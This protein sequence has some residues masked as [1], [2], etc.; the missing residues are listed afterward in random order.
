MK[1]AFIRFL[2]LCPLILATLAMSAQVVTGTPAFGTFKSF[3]PTVLNIANLNSRVTIPIMGKP[4]RGTPFNYAMTYDNSVW[5]PSGDPGSLSWQP[6]PNFGWHGMSEAITGYLSYRTATRPCPDHVPGSR[7][8]FSNFVYHDKFG[9]PHSFL[10]IA[11]TDTDCDDARDLLSQ[12]A[13]DGSGYSLTF[14]PNSG[15]PTEIHFVNGVVIH[16]PENDPNGSG[17][18]AD[19]NGNVISTNMANGVGTFIDTLG[20]TALTVSGAA[21]N[22][23][24]LAYTDSNGASQSV[25]LNYQA[26]SVRTN[27]GCGGIAEY[28]ATNKPLIV[29]IVFPDQT[30]YKFSYESTPGDA[31]SVTGRIASVTL[32]TGVTINY[33][34]PGGNNG[35]V[36]DDGSSAGVNVTTSDGGTWQYSRSGSGTEW[37]TT[38]TDPAGNQ[39]VYNFSG[40]YETQ[41]LAYSGVAAPGHAVFFRFTC[42]FDTDNPQGCIQGVVIPPISVKV[43]QVRLDN[44]QTGWTKT[45]YNNQGLPTEFDQYHYGSGQVGQLARKTVINYVSLGNN[46]FDRQSDITVYDMNGQQVAKTTFSYDDTALIATPGLPQHVPVTG[47]RG[48]LTH[49]NEWLNTSNGFLTTTYKYFDTGMLQSV[50]DP[51]GHV[52]TFSYDST[53]AYASQIALPDTNSPGPAHHVNSA[54]YDTHTGLLTSARDE[55]GNLT[56]FFYDSLLRPTQTNLPDGGLIS[57][58]Y[59]DANHVT[60][61]QLI[62]DP[63]MLFSETELDGY[64]RASRAIMANGEAAPFDIQDFCYDSM[65]RLAFRSSPYQGSGLSAAKVCFGAGDRYEYDALGRITRLTHSDGSSVQYSYTGRATQI[66]DEGNAVS[67]ILQLDALGR[68]T[69]VCEVSNSTLLGSGGTPASCGLDIAATGFLT[70]YGYDALDNLTTVTQ[71]SLANRSYAYD[72]LGRMTSELELEWGSTTS[73][74][75]DS[76]SLLVTRVRPAPNQQPGSNVQ[77]TTTYTYD[78]LHRP[79]SISYDDGKT[80]G[81]L[82]NYDELSAGGAALNNSIGRMTSAMSSSTEAINSFD[83]IGRIVTSWQRTPSVTTPFQLDYRYDLS[84]N[85]IS[86]T[87]VAGAAFNYSYNTAGRLTDMLSSVGDIHHPPQLLSNVHYGAFGMVSAALG[88]GV[89][90]SAS[91]TPR[92]LLQTYAAVAVPPPNAHNYEGFLDHAGCDNIFGWAAD[93]NSLNTA[94]T[95]TIYDNGAALSTVLANSF[96]PDVGAYLGDN[97]LHGFGIPTPASMRDGVTHQVSVKF[98]NGAELG[99]SPKSLVCP[100]STVSLTSSGS[101]VYGQNV[102]FTVHV[103]AIGGSAVPTGAVTFKDG[104]QVLGTVPLDSSVQA[105]LG[106]SLLSAGTHSITASYGGDSVFPAGSDQVLQVVTPAALS[107]TAASAS[108]LYGAANPVFTGTL[109]GLQNNDNITVS[110]QSAATPASPVGAYVINPVLSDPG[111]KLGNYTVT[112]LNGTLSVTPAPLIVS[113]NSATRVYGAPNPVFTGTISGLQNNDNIAPNFTTFA[114]AGSNVGTYPISPTLADPGGRLPNYAVSST[115]GVLTVT[116]ASLQVIVNN[117]T[118][119][120]LDPNPPL[121]G[122][123]TGIRNGDNITAQYTT[124]ATPQSLLGTYPINA[125]LL[126]PAGKLGNYTTTIQPGTLTVTRSNIHLA[127]PTFTPASGVYPVGQAIT[128]SDATSSLAAIHYTTDGST[129]WAGSPLYTGPIVLNGP[130]TFVAIAMQPEYLDSGLATATY[131]QIPILVT[132]HTQEASDCMPV[133]YTVTVPAMNGLSGSL[134]LSVSGLPKGATATFTPESI[135]SPGSSTLTVTIPS[136]PKGTVPLL[137]PLMVTVTDGTVTGTA[138]ATI[139]NKNPQVCGP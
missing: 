36:C 89:Q 74:T 105:F 93:R 31:A 111:G 64:G 96:R 82:F 18:V 88:N 71:G 1:P 121:D 81:T 69:Q 19:V 79:L 115:P 125:T 56:T 124:P 39:T 122:T 59:P 132:P 20:T 75:Y 46:I 128:I 15:G 91:F 33:A 126:D 135:G 63:F 119:M 42:Y 28:S 73:Y 61:Q 22:P 100:S 30:S 67:R 26:F 68:L 44:A 72:S 85:L 35:I 112:L 102:G 17:S 65:G 99:T 12:P 13:S 21:P 57:L 104:N 94:I 133:I 101:S 113:V 24:S 29:S 45:F 43:D 14:Q 134:V 53:G 40:I 86:S 84:G 3:G 70:S 47:S 107:A 80:D 87:S 11:V 78:A 25:V 130:A 32:P 116:P 48:N 95:V 60:A 123:I 129:P 90:E 34:Y 62:N 4:G 127:V 27:F 114:T 49:R 54:N 9:V 50:S 110:F 92:G 55:N 97:G 5:V 108:R 109:S 117:K 120:Y 41:M 136:G 76:D 137:I 52:A 6:Q 37:V 118:R 51:G 8:V 138:S 23:V 2:F 10:G 103:S 16:P 131:N 7:T 83:S 139:K 77:V 58:R 38:E 98:E 66:T 106:T